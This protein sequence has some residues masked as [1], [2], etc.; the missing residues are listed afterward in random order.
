VAFFAAG[1]NAERASGRILA[2]QEARAPDLLV[3]RPG[4]R[5]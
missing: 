4:Y 2:V 5:N 1:S 3:R